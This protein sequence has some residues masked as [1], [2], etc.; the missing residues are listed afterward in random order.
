M[1]HSDSELLRQY[2]DGHLDDAL[3]ELVRRHVDLVY[4]TALRRVGGDDHFA[5]DVVQQVFADFVRKAATL[6]G[7]AGLSGWFYTSAHYAA[8]KLVRGE[9]RR[10]SRE[11]E[12]SLMNEIDSGPAPEVVWSELRPVLDDAMH[13]LGE[14]DRETVL[15]RYFEQRPLAEVGNRLGISENAASKAVER[16]L[17]RLRERFA[18]RGITSTSSALALAFANRAIATAPAGL[19]PTVTAS[20]LAGDFIAVG[21]AT[22]VLLMLKKL[23]I[24]ILAALLPVMSAGFY[25][26]SMKV[27]GLEAEVAQLR[28]DNLP[29]LRRRGPAPVSGAAPTAAATVATASVQPVPPPEADVKVIARATNAG[30]AT[31][32]A[33]YETFYW[34]LEHG[35]I[36][37]L[38]EDTAYD[39]DGRA[40]LRKIFEALSREAQA[41]YGTPEIMA[42]AVGSYTNRMPVTQLEILGSKSA[43]PDA[44]MISYRRN[45]ERADRSIPMVNGDD[46]WKVV[47]RGSVFMDRGRAEA[48]LSAAE[49]LAANPNREA[50][51]RITM[52]PPPPKP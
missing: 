1:N 40:I 36:K 33:A 30:R 10:K 11:A 24:V 19:A 35:D 4:S 51:A 8:A 49:E 52:P 26:K 41:F 46:G 9:R 45:G 48:F 27:R 42:A 7:R 43:G 34:A 18:Q 32:A 29:V 14:R 13:D 5:E 2:L 12:T 20:L 17:D 44:V 47:G 28:T 38:A 37:L 6:R 50:G 39:D 22:S 16:A 31:P 23:S 15:L 25:Y 3:A 21:G